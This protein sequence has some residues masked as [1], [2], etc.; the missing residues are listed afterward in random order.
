MEEK[1]V[2]SNKVNSSVAAGNDIVAD[3]D[4]KA[5]INSITNILLQR[6]YLTPSFNI[7]LPKYIGKP[8]TDMAALSLGQDIEKGLALFERRVKVK[9][10]LVLPDKD[11]NLYKIYLLIEMPNFSNRVM[12]LEGLLDNVGRLS[13]INK[14]SL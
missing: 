5:I 4:E 14:E 2:S 10:I 1:K 7:N 13:F 3:Y 8:I 12:T 9:K 11:N 6:R